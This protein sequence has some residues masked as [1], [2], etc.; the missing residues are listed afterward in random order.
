MARQCKILNV[1]EK[2]DA[3]REISKVMAGGRVQRVKSVMLRFSSLKRCIQIY[4]L[5]YVEGRILQIQ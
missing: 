1:A 3:A 5:N 2:N 4:L